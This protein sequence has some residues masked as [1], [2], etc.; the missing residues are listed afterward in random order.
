VLF[1]AGQKEKSA[2]IATG[3]RLPAT[4]LAALAAR[5]GDPSAARQLLNEAEDLPEEQLQP[6]VV[7][8]RLAAAIPDWD[9]AFSWMAEAVG[10]RD[11]ELP[12]LL[13]SPLI[14]KSDPRFDEILA[15]MNLTAGPAR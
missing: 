15:H 14:P 1:F 13:W 4:L 8:A 9:R 2:E 12:Y 6:A 5:Q 10:E 3:A 7:Y 11:G